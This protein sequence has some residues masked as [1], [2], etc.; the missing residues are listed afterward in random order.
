ML[1]AREGVAGTHETPLG[2]GPLALPRRHRLAQ[3]VERQVVHVLDEGPE[4]AGESR[5]TGIATACGFPLL[6]VHHVRRRGYAS[7]TAPGTSG[8]GRSLVPVR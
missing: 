4:R 1:G 3:Q 2:V 5:E 8:A 6:I 7:A